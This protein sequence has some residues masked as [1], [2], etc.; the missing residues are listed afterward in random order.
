MAVAGARLQLEG[1]GLR[2]D[3]RPGAVLRTLHGAAERAHVSDGGVRGAGVE[4]LPAVCARHRHHRSP[5]RTDV[6]IL[7][8]LLL[9]PEV[10]R[11]A[12][13]DHQG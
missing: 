8:R 13:R 11:A 4:Q 9:R 3:V 6:R 2:T 12:A 1:P 5:A 7:H 10:R